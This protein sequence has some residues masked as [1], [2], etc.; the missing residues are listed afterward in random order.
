MDTRR[1]LV[2]L[3]LWHVAGAAALGCTLS[4]EDKEQAVLDQCASG[5]KE[6]LTEGNLVGTWQCGPDLGGVMEIG[7][8]GVVY[9]DADVDAEESQKSLGCV[10]CAGDYEALSTEDSGTSTPDFSVVNGRLELAADDPDV[11]VTNWDWCTHR[12]IDAC[13][14]APNGSAGRGECV[15]GD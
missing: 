8:D 7:E 4:E 1:W 10:T 11:L 5:P 13:R 2:F 12:D 15:R 6:C 9:F 14:E 3:P